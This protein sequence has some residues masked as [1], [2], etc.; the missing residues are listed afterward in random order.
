[1]QR[2]LYGDEFGSNSGIFFLFL[3]KPCPA[4]PGYTLS[5]Q[6]V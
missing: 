2:T 4:D 5:L 3:L 6:T 1:M